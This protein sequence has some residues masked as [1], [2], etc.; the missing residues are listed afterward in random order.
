MKLSIFLLVFLQSCLYAQELTA[1]KNDSLNEWRKKAYEARIK[2][3]KERCREDSIRAEHDSKI[4]NK[5]YINIAAPYG[6]N[7]LPG[8]ELKEVL[9]KH[10]IIWGGEWMG[11]DS[12]GYS[13]GCY[14]S[15]MTELTEK[16]FG[17]D[18]VDGLV[19]E[20]VAQYVK[21]HP[22]KIFDR[23]EH[24]EWTYK[25]TYLIYNDG[26]D[27]LNKDFFKNVPYP[28]GYQNYAPSQKY[29]SNTAVTLTLNEKG[30]VLKE[31][32]RHNIY[33]DHNLK[34]I[35]YFE[36]EIKKFIKYTTFEP[37]KYGGY[38]VKSE[39]SFFIYYK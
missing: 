13:G 34:Y 22:G 20:S 32:F 39:T 15:M 31:E 10:T 26:N 21:K 3:N 25:G 5:Y 24:T 28:E 18:F 14:Y 29:H 38:P 8:E 17:K 1:L 11:S 9:K 2:Y 19:A 36:K 12:G 6:D 23:N 16:K 30:K 33:N 7:F 35:P 4:Q 37:V 27:L